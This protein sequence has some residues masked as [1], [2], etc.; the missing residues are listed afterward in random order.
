MKIVQA[1]EDSNILLKG[2]TKTIKNETK[3][4]KGRFLSMLLGTLGASLLGNLLT[5]KG[6]VRAG[7]ENKKGK[8][9]VSA[10]SGHP[11]YENIKGKGIVRAGT[12]NKKEW[13][14]ECRL[15]L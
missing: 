15:I 9:I 4:Q 5:G 6:T 12:R 11:S 1:L 10:G 7:S 3:E 14:F 2:V 8:G 13:D